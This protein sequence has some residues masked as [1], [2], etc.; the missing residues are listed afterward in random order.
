MGGFGVRRRKMTFPAIMTV[1]ISHTTNKAILFGITRE[2]VIELAGECTFEGIKYKSL[3]S[4]DEVFITQTTSGILPV[5]EID[6]QK[7]GDGHP[8]PVTKK[9]MNDFQKLVWGK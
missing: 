2:T 8:G 3:L 4:A 7:I 5:I 9:L 6:G 1:T